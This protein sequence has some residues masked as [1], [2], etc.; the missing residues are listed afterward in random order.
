MSKSSKLDLAGGI[1]STQLPW[2][3]YA[4]TVVSK[5]EGNPELFDGLWQSIYDSDTRKANYA[6][7]FIDKCC[8]KQPQLV[9]GKQA[10]IIAYLPKAL[11][12][13]IQRSLLRVLLRYSIPEESESELVEFCFNSLQSAQIPVAVKVHAMQHIYNLSFKYPELVIE[14]VPVIEQQIPL[15]SVG[16][17]SRS[18]KLLKAIRKRGI[19]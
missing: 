16:F 3:E 12:T 19:A 1:Y 7:W 13:G 11:R 18:A 17:R 15:S 9:E 14:L 10:E 6:A 4:K 2:S 5:I 8:E